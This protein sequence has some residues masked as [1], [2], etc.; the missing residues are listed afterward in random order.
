MSKCL[1]MYRAQRDSRDELG[2]DRGIGCALTPI[3]KQMMVTRS[4]TMLSREESSR[5]HTG[6][7][8][9]PKALMM[10]E[11]RVIEYGGRYARKDYEYIV[12]GILIYVLLS[13]HGMEYG[14]GEGADQ[15]G[16]DH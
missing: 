4:S 5:N 8:E 11:V 6:V 14:A 7:L 9:S 3:S 1:Y 13:V 10:L 12:I 15:Q 16:D 2:K